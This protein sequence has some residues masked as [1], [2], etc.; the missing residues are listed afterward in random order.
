KGTERTVDDARIARAQHL[1]SD[2]EPVGDTRAKCFDEDIGGIGQL[3]QCLAL[4]RLLQI[5]HDT[6]LTA[7]EIAEEHGAR[8]VREANLTAWIAAAGSLNLD[9]LRAM[10]GERLGE[11]RS[12]EKPRQLD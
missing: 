11:I 4:R 10:I 12:G 7:V 8:S 1:I 3:E 5:Q 6:L 2:T 9:N